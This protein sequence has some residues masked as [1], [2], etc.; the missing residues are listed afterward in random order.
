MKRLSRRALLRG[1]SGVA[2][3]LPLLDAMMPRT[4]RAQDAAAP[5]RIIFVFQANGDEVDQRFTQ[6]GE[7]AF[8]FGDFLSPLEPY[9]DELLILNKLDRRFSELPEDQRADNHQQGGSSLAPWTSGAGSYPIGGSE[10][11]TI[12][13]VQGPSADYEI[14]NRVIADNPSV[15][16]RHL[17]YRVGQKHN[18]IW[19]LHSHGGPVGQQNPVPPET[20][21][22]AAYTRI[23]TF[24]SGDEDAQAA[25]KRRLAKRQSALDLVQD[26]VN[27]LKSRIGSADK[28]KL[29][30]H[31]ESLRDIERTLQGGNGA[32]EC[33]PLDLG[34]PIDAY[35]DENHAIVGELFFKI[36]AL[37][38]ACDLTRSVN[39]NWSGNTSGRV[40]KN[41]GHDEGHHDISHNSDAAAFERIRAIHKH[42]W[43][44]NTKLYDTLK[45]IPELG[46][47]IWD[48]TL[49]VHWNE[50]AQGDSHALSDGLVVLAGGAHNYF[51][52]GRL[53]EFGNESS[54]SDMLVNCFH[55]MGYDDVTTFGDERLKLAGSLT[56]VTA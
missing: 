43:T 38:F 35:A 34:T 24:N 28:Q 42:L 22:Y 54:F 51:R 9:R 52:R 25:I 55:Y 49:V 6:T 47:T 15:P 46:G 41:L 17:V 39:F 8:Q 30:L 36:S 5:R 20:D 19:N 48:H 21:P 31:A 44:Q 2:L 45:S 27:T 16:Y 53:L 4:V 10:G 13:Y 26:E 18:D 33:K 50:L 23:F 14:G 3:G 1:A 11:K 37:A 29:E 12:G 40:Y 56:G 32:A 7:T